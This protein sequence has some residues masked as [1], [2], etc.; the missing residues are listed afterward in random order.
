MSAKSAVLAASAVA[1]VALG[2]YLLIQV[3]GTV[4]PVTP[5]LGSEPGVSRRPPAARDD[6]GA[7]ARARPAP[8][9]TGGE[10]DARPAR[11]PPPTAGGGDV[12]PP[13]PTPEDARPNLRFD[14]LMELA[15]KHYDQ[16]DFETAAAIAS[17]VLSKD[18]G[19]VRM[20][21]IVV[22]ANCIAGDSAVAQ[23][24]YERLPAFDREQMRARCDRYGVT[25]KEPAR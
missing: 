21:R 25:F 15:N 5:T 7:P 17:K 8:R 19:N 4:A 2:I 12:A 24:H 16:Q 6:Q 14:N 22:S 3:R 1:V 23:E 10:A 9:A 11:T 13:V 18:P 20:L